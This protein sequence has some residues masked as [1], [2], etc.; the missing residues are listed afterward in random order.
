MSSTFFAPAAA[1][2]AVATTT[3]WAAAG[4]RMSK[5]TIGIAPEGVFSVTLPTRE[6]FLDLFQMNAPNLD[7]AMRHVYGIKVVDEC[8]GSQF[9]H[10]LV[11]CYAFIVPDKGVGE[12]NSEYSSQGRAP[13]MTLQEFVNRWMSA[14]QQEELKEYLDKVVELQAMPVMKQEFRSW[15]SGSRSSS[16][17]RSKSI[18]GRLLPCSHPSH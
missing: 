12:K 8:T 5:R 15:S 10:M 18:R 6:G 2:G 16:W 3:A 17:Q 7:E 13:A 14:E 4:H 1:A 9:Q 11:G